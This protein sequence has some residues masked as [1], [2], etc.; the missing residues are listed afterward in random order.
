MSSNEIDSNR[1]KELLR[2]V[3]GYKVQKGACIRSLNMG[4]ISVAEADEEIRM[5]SARI[6]KAEK[7]LVDGVHKRT[8]QKCKPT[9]SY[10]K[11]YYLT[12]LE[13]IEAE[14]G[15]KKRK[16]IKAKTEA[17]MYSKLYEYYFGDASGYT[18][19]K[20]FE[21]ALDYK[22]R[23]KNR[24]EGTIAKDENNYKRFISDD[25]ARMDIREV[26]DETLMEYTQNLV[27]KN[28]LKVKAFSSYKGTLNLI[29]NFA[30]QKDI[31]A[32]NP[33]VYIENSDYLKSCD[34]TRPGVEEETYSE[35]EIE[36]MLE[37]LK[38]RR[39]LARYQHCFGQEYAVRFAILTGVRLGELVAMKWE[40]IDLKGGVIHI[41]AQQVSRH[42]EEGHIVYERVL[43]TKN[44]RG[45]SNDGRYFP[46]TKGIAE[47]LEE[48]RTKY[49]EE[50]ITSEYIFVHPDGR[51]FNI[52]E[53]TKYLRNLCKKIGCRTTK[54]HAFRKSVNS[55][56]ASEGL[57]ASDRAE[58]LGHS[59]KTN[60]EHYTYKSRDCVEK[61][62]S[63]FDGRSETTLTD[64]KGT[65]LNK[66]GTLYTI[67]FEKKKSPKPLSL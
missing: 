47:L 2:I 64:E 61:A 58:L 27:Q 11:G 29:F 4:I 5:T 55:Y 40:D 45:I 8:I 22:K 17:E 42:D 10:P 24:T 14:G 30:V 63:I 50:G 13:P 21:L 12:E 19:G 31:I 56:L 36:K 20:V 49:E 1:I 62:R 7:E 9:A 26:T 37:E 57:Q 6:R 46:I 35:E 3:N 32:K 65:I 48:I 28:S 51:W 33:A 34:T 52:H 67:P 25:L 44:E 15:K 18:V 39:G 53:Y 60:L 66:K 38:R 16:K 59:V 54:N 41:H 23:C 43:Y